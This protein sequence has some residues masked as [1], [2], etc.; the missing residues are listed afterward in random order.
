MI[1][2]NGLLQIVATPVALAL[3]LLV[4]GMALNKHL[5]ACE[6]ASA[7]VDAT[8]S[9]LTG[10]M[11]TQTEI[12]KRVEAKGDQTAAKAAHSESRIARLEGLHDG[13]KP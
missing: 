3:L 12:L 2:L 6:A 11:T 9:L 7:K 4:I 5:K 1:D 13:E 8:L 10:A